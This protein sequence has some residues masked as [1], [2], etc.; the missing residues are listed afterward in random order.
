MQ[1]T[2]VLIPEAVLYVGQNDTRGWKVAFLVPNGA[3]PISFTYQGPDN[4]RVTW[5]L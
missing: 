5:K 2:T 3:Q 4:Q 1:T